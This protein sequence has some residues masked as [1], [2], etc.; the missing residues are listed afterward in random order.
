MAKICFEEFEWRK[1]DPLP[2]AMPITSI[3]QR[4]GGYAG[5]RPFSTTS[6]MG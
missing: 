2:L 3:W 1:L 6:I 5:S 4:R